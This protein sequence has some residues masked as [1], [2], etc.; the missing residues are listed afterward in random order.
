M[1]SLLMLDDDPEVCRAFT[2]LFR[3]RGIDATAGTSS[4]DFMALARAGGHRALLI[5]VSDG[6]GTTV[7][8]QLRSAG[9]RRPLGLMSANLT[10]GHGQ[11]PALA[12]GA[13]TFI[14]KAVETECLVAA[15]RALLERSPRAAPAPSGRMP[16][17]RA[18]GTTLRA[19]RIDCST[20]IE[21]RGDL[22]FVHEHLLELRPKERAVLRRLIESAGSVVS[23]DTLARDVW[24]LAAT[25][26]TTVIKTTVSRLRE[27]LGS[28][29]L[30]I[31]AVGDGYTIR[32]ASERLRVTRV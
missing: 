20:T 32:H 16:P 22:V 12:A 11:K 14:D 17:A 1:Y 6:E 18:S 5:D 7:C 31:E 24:G 28:A 30:L 4:D 8:W 10:F 25:P 13:D 29:G 23:R 26:A 19:Q 27:Q 21:L 2:R 9:E 3:S 15:V